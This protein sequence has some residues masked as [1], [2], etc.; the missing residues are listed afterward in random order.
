MKHQRRPILMTALGVATLVVLF[1]AV[2]V[3]A[4]QIPPITVSFQ[5]FWTAAKGK[6]FVEQEA[7]WNKY[8]EGPREKFYRSVVWEA[9]NYP[10]WRHL[11]AEM[12][13]ARFK[14]Y[15]D[16][17]AKVPAEVKRIEAAIQLESKRFRKFFPKATLHPPVVLAFAPDFDSKSGLMPNGK[18]VLALS[19]GTLI[20]EKANLKILLPHELFHL[21]DAERAGVKND[22]VM[23][24]TTLKLPLFAEGLATYVSSVVSP[25]YDDSH[26]LFQKNL[27]TLPASRLPEAAKDFLKVAGVMTIDPKSHAISQVYVRWFEGDR[28]QLQRDLPNRAGYWLGLN[29]IRQLRKM[30]SLRQ[31]AAWPPAK[32]EA[33]METALTTLANKTG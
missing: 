32:A 18:P 30:Y 1:S 3:D 31:I 25:G 33:E 4:M 14:E 2:N 21:Y 28:K 5:K 26:Y 22:G 9:R 13:K 27:G 7:A 24:G 6:P 23:P 11:K 10:N 17:A 19:V 8:I 20:L 12:L 29:L 16:I 15:P